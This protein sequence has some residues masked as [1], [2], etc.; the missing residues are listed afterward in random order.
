MMASLRLR[1]KEESSLPLPCLVVANALAARPTELHPVS[2]Q[3]GG[4][5][6][7]TSKEGQAE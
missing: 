6:D 2:G 5:D 4:D 7:K 1:R 3:R